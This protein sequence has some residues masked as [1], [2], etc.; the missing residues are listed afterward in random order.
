M[1]VLQPSAQCVS[2]ETQNPGHGS[3]GESAAGGHLE[4]DGDD[5]VNICIRLPLL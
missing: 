3:M 5:S 2:A 4:T 1:D